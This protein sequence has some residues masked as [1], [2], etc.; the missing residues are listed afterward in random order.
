MTVSMTAA[1]TFV[2]TNV[3][4]YAHDPAD[5][6]KRAIAEAIGSGE[7]GDR[8]VI[9]TQVL[10][11]FYSVVTR[12]LSQALPA[13]VAAARVADLAASPTIPTDAALV[14][15]AVALSRS[16]QLSI[17]DALIVAAAQVGRC[18]RLL[19]E[20]LSHGMTYGSVTIENPFRDA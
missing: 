19:S 14:R 7:R 12:K 20:D 16:A 3:L 9:S 10:V 11:E 13:E 1:R 15:M 4:V 6:R 5:P 18:T 17:W 2:D 8:L